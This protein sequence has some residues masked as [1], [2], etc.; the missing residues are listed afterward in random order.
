MLTR[1]ALMAL[2]TIVAA[3]AVGGGVGIRLAH[4]RGGRE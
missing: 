1:M 2:V 3:V 4:G